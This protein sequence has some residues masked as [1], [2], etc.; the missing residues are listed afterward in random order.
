MKRLIFV[1]ILNFILASYFAQQLLFATCPDCPHQLNN[2]TLTVTPTLMDVNDNGDQV[3]CLAVAGNC[4][5]PVINAEMVAGEPA[6]TLSTEVAFADNNVTG[7]ALPTLSQRGTAN[8]TSYS[9]RWGYEITLPQSLASIPLSITFNASLTATVYN[10]DNTVAHT[11]QGTVSVNITLERS[12]TD[13]T[14]KPCTD[15]CEPIEC[16]ECVAASEPDATC[17]VETSATNAALGGQGTMI[18]A[19]AANMRI[20]NFSHNQ[21]QAEATLDYIID[22]QDAA[23][24]GV[25]LNFRQDNK[26]GNGVKFIRTAETKKNI[27][28]K[29]PKFITV[30]LLQYGPI[31]FKEPKRLVYDATDAEPN[32]SY[33]FSIPLF[34]PELNTGNYNWQARLIKEYEDGT[35][36]S[37]DVM[38]RQGFFNS[39]ASALS[40]GW[41]FGLTPKLQA[42]GDDVLFLYQ[43]MH[44]FRKDGKK[45]IAPKT[46]DM[47]DYQLTGDWKR[48]FELTSKDKTVRKFDTRVRIVSVTKADG[49]F[50]LYK[51]DSFENHLVQ[52]SLSSGEVTNFIY[53]DATGYLREVISPQNKKTQFEQDEKGRIVKVTFPDPDDDGPLSPNI[54]RFAYDNEGLLTSIIRPNGAETKYEYDHAKRLS[55]ITYP[56][57]RVE[58]FICP[59]T[60]GIVDTKNGEGTK[61][62]PAKLIP[63]NSIF[64]T[65]IVVGTC[66]KI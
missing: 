58:S 44:K 59:I 42:D 31:L 32:K 49:N 46:Y 29:K 10:A 2:L 52:K 21:G 40:T 37:L 33:R 22:D 43:G 17:P 65:E 5:A 38:G 15:I 63:T 66:E 48:G 25:D 23:K 54:L 13:V 61:D 47:S 62:K 35:S 7:I 6:W 1:L 12:S 64:N 24:L 50:V 14:P 27:V 16:D 60:A 51:Y 3:Y 36:E 19:T 18:F 39:Q 26:F 53:D 45:W 11:Y 30:E 9:A 28:T 56:D 8:L 4:D 34:L 20:Q 41:V 55:K 57:G